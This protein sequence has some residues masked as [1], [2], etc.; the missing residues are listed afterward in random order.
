MMSPTAK[1]QESPGDTFAT[2]H[3]PDARNIHLSQLSPDAFKDPKQKKPK[4][5]L[6]RRS[7]HTICTYKSD[8]SEKLRNGYK[9]DFYISY[10]F[11]G[12]IQEEDGRFSP[13]NDLIEIVSKNVILDP[14]QDCEIPIK[15]SDSITRPDEA[16]VTLIRNQG[17]IRPVPRRDHQALLITDNKFLLVYG[18]KNDNAFSYTTA[19]ENNL[20]DSSFYG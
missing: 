1:S 3:S 19:T 8:N 17:G 16:Q 18:G 12:L 20:G 11:G 15:T 2:E 14:T 13:T 5:A 6:L 4:R 10:V 9:I 7:H